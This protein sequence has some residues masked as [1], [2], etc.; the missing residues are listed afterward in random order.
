MSLRV[1]TTLVLAAS[2][3]ALFSG[4]AVSRLIPA[5]AE[6]GVTL[7]GSVHGGQQPVAQAHVYLLAAASSNYGAAATSLLTS[8]TSGSDS[9]GGYVLTDA[10]GNFSITGD[11]T[12][13]QGQQVYVYALGGNPGAGSNAA[14]GMIAAV[15][16]CP[17]AGNFLGAVPYINVNELTTVA[18]AYAVAGFAV[19]PTH[20][21]DSGNALS[22]LDMANAFA[23]TANLLHGATPTGGNGTV[24]VAELNTLGNILAACINSTGAVTGPTSPTPCYTLLNSAPA[25]S[26]IP[27]NTAAAA[28]N[29]AHNPAANVSALYGLQVASA[30]FAPALSAAPADFTVALTFTGGGLGTSAAQTNLSSFTVNNIAIDA[31]GNVWKPNYG[32]NTLSEFSPLGVPL[33]G[34]GGFS[35]GGLSTPANVAV[36]LSGNIWVG[37]FAGNSVSKFASTGVAVS[38]S[39]FSGGGI[40]S[41]A[42]LAVDPSG[43]VWVAN[44]STVSKLSST[45]AAASGSPFSTNSLSQAT[46]IAITLAGNVWVTDASSNDTVLYTNAGAAV[47]GS[48]YTGGAQNYPY[49]IAFDASGRAWIADQS[50]I[51]RLSSTGTGATSFDAPSG[52]IPTSIAV[53]GL[54]NVWV[55]EVGNNTILELNSVGS[56]IS[57]SVGF[58]TGETAVPEAVAIDGSGNLWYSTCN[59]ATIHELVGAAAPVITPLSSA[60]G[61]NGVGARP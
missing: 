60:V 26:T 31:A 38:G 1:A 52:A 56:Y 41:P 46:G 30:P 53:D 47:S 58:Q 19:D 9:V 20:V 3:L 44:T 6:P 61:R 11:Y 12:C 35:G 8:G 7:Q 27:T 10:N 24:P 42:N 28:I 40:T 16:N 18:F 37:N 49:G 25:G 48:P 22:D 59:D 55:A 51:T 2:A 54:G 50:A 17:A 33:S 39:P 32:T 21:A 14:S 57:G 45:G 4:C 43:N 13:T 36:D 29:I 34:A 15:G 23:N 5:S